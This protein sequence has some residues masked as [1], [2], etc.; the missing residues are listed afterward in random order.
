MLDARCCCRFQVRALEKEV[1][2]MPEACCLAA[3]IVTNVLS[4]LQHDPTICNMS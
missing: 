1:A 3:N 2:S 4:Q